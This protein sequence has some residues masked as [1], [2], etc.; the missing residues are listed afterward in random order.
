M[1]Y[2]DVTAQ[3]RLGHAAYNQVTFT[4]TS[5]TS[6]SCNG[7]GQEA[8]KWIKRIDIQD[9]APKFHCDLCGNTGFLNID[10]EEVV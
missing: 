4:A 8:S 1:T 7:C 9:S 2:T 6:L 3:E 5:E 10:D